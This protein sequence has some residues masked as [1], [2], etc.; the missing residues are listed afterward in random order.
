M[1]RSFKY[2]INNLVAL[3]FYSGACRTEPLDFFTVDRF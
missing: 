3:F 2:T 1:K